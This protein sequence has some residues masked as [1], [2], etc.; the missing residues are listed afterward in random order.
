MS[1]GRN[2]RWDIQ[3]REIGILGKSQDCDI[4]PQTSWSQMYEVEEW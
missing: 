3:Q 1:G 2:R 4:L